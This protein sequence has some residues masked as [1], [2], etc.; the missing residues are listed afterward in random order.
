MQLH[1]ILE[2]QQQNEQ[3]KFLQAENEQLTKS[4]KEATGTTRSYKEQELSLQEECNQLGQ[5]LKTKKQ[6]L[7]QQKNIRSLR[8]ENAKLKT[9]LTRSRLDTG[10]TEGKSLILCTY[11]KIHTCFILYT[12]SFYGADVVGETE[13]TVS[14]NGRSYEWKQYGLKLHVPESSLSAGSESYRI[15]I[16]VTLSGHFEFPE[17]SEL[18]SPIF[19]ISVPRKFLKPVI[20]EIQH[21]VIT[22]DVASISD[23][24]FVTAKRNRLDLPYKFRTL[25]GG[26]FTPYSSYGS[27]SVSHFCGIGCTSKKGRG[28]RQNYCAHIYYKRKSNKEW[29]VYFVITKDLEAVANVSVLLYY[30]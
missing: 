23:L 5:H 22:E 17:D 19:W 25:D 10:T 21:C 11:N 7:Q 29:S 15:S 3:I 16:K 14:R 24:S 26:V 9:Q 30:V 6:L 18:V 20:V 4:L 27:I 13:I 1:N 28:R 8:M 2:D 12:G